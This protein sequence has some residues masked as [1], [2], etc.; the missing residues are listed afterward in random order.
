MFKGIFHI[1]QFLLAIAVLAISTSYY[2][3]SV[4]EYVI[5]EYI[6]WFAII[7]VPGLSLLVAGF[8]LVGGGFFGI[9]GGTF[10]EGLKMGLLIG[11]TNGIARLWPYL[12]A[13]SAG[14]YF[15][16]QPLLKV[17]G[18]ALIGAVVYSLHLAVNYFWHNIQNREISH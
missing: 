3:S 5:P 10:L 1:L 8:S 15:G 13:W 11:L 7:G 17:I 9:V 6:Y 2:D 18:I 4:I 12:L 16:N 14:A